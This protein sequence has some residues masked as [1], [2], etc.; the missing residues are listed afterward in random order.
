MPSSWSATGI[1]LI[2]LYERGVGWIVGHAGGSDKF[3][4]THAGL[5]IWLATSAFS[6]RPLGSALPL[7]TVAIL[8]AGNETIDRLAHGSWRWSDTLGDIAATLFWPS[9]M[10]LCIRLKPRLFRSAGRR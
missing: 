8:E 6:R 9:V 2:A 3:V 1:K 4:H 5:A 10:T 7:L